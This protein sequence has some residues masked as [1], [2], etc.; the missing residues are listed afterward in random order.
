M[1]G[2][3]HFVALDGL[4]GI[5]AL[6]VMLLHL[7]ESFPA[8]AVRNQA[9]L[10]VD[11][12]FMLSGFVIGYAYE[13]KLL[14]GMARD[15]FYAVRLVR[16]YPMVLMGVLFGAIARLSSGEQS[17]VGVAGAAVVALLMIPLP[18]FSPTPM[19]AFPLN[20]PLWSLTFEL[21]S[22]IVY[23]LVLPWLTTRRL[24]LFAAVMA[25]ALIMVGIFQGELYMGPIWSRGML[26][27][28][29]RLFAPFSIGLLIFR[30]HTVT[31]IKVEGYAI[32]ASLLL[33]LS[34]WAPMSGGLYDVTIVLLVFPIVIML[35][36]HA[37]DTGALRS[38]WVWLGGLSFPLYAIH[39]PILRMARTVAWAQTFPVAFPIVTGI[40]C[41]AMA[42]TLRRLYDEPVRRWLAARVLHRA[43]DRRGGDA[44]AAVEAAPT[45]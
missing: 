12:F 18:R 11:F 32:V 33:L 6:S 43:R 14:G 5:A 25:V 10:G 19:S 1:N 23:A 41:I 24:G 9:Q 42:E 7:G 20:G 8:I 38:T 15:R 4:R 37:P 40:G 16:L 44:D 17:V 3:R 13:A 2:K 21:F 39:H 28:F 35:A 31:R 22:N 27:A 34:L 30:I 29:I 36:M 45:N 26:T